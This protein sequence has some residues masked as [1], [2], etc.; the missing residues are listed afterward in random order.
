MCE[1]LS[2][3]LGQYTY[4][5]GR[6]AKSLLTLTALTTLFAYI[7]ELLSESGYGIPGPE[8]SG[9]RL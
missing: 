3:D 8:Q 2:R 5:K 1:G 7:P 9:Y 6:P 4:P